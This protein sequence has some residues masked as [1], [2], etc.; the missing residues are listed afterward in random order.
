M[1]VGQIDP[2]P[3]LISIWNR[4]NRLNDTQH[5][6]TQ[7]IGTQHKIKNGDVMKLIYALLVP[8]LSHVTQHNDTQ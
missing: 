6:D 3:I 2:Q 8:A 7:H 4:D 5:N 1:Q